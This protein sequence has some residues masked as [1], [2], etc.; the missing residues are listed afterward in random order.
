MIKDSYITQ[1][2]IETNNSPMDDKFYSCYCIHGFNPKYNCLKCCK[3][4]GIP[5]YAYECDICG[6]NVE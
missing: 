5:F 2:Y 1:Y 6:Y 4:C 3:Y